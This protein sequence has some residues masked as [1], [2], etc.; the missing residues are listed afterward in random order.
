MSKAREL[1]VHPAIASPSPDGLSSSQNAALAPWNVCFPCAASATSASPKR[2]R[3]GLWPPSRR[4]FLRSQAR[5]PWP[6]KPLPKIGE[7]FW[8]H[9]KC[10]WQY[11]HLVWRGDV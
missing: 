10:R 4:A 9:S 6:R 8:E 5:S 2:T 3:I 7:V 1:K 11:Q